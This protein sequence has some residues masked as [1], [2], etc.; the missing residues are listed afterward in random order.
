MDSP[1]CERCGHKANNGYII[2]NFNGQWLCGDCIIYIKQ[3][4]HD[5]MQRI[6]KEEQNAK[7]EMP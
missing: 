5:I 7:N 1:Q 3:K 6:I 2:C 4:Y